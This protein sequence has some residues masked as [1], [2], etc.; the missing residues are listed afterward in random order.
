MLFLAR[1]SGGEF[2][3]PT[4]T[5]FALRFALGAARF[6][7]S[8]LAALVLLAATAPVAA[9]G[10]GVK[11]FNLGAFRLSGG[12]S[13]SGCLGLGVGWRFR[14]FF[15][16]RSLRRISGFVFRRLGDRP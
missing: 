7:V 1:R 9:P 11:D 16:G 4:L 14:R 8:A 12:F 2:L 10:K 13:D 5:R 15:S 3:C 6:F